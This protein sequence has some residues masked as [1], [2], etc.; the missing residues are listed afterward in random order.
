M[1]IYY[2][3]RP[4][5]TCWYIPDAA[6]GVA[7]LSVPVTAMTAGIWFSKLGLG[8]CHCLQSDRN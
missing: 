1:Y 3:R 4:Y 5:Y 8:S 6:A 2:M 7:Y